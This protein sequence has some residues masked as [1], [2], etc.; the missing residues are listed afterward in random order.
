MVL[1]RISNHLDLNG[2][3]GERGNARWHTKLPGRRIIYLAEHPALAL[4]ETLVNLRGKKEILPDRFQ[5]L[6]I[7]IA[8]ATVVETILEDALPEDWRED[9]AATQTLGNE[10]L[11]RR[12]SALVAVP[13]APSPESTNYLLNPLHPDAAGCKVVWSRWVR[14]DRRL[15]RLSE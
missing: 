8:P 4:V 11:A 14:F 2:L 1:W 13:S 3:G 7:E 6:R 5:L 15:F 9:F 10:W 12:S